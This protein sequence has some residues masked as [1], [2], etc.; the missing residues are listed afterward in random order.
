M[1]SIP[2]TPSISTQKILHEIIDGT[3]TSYKH[4]F[5][6]HCPFL[7]RT[8]PFRTLF[9][10]EVL[11]DILRT[12]PPQQTTNLIYVA[13]LP[14]G[15]LFDFLLLTKLLAHGYHSLTV[16][17]IEPH[18]KKSEI[19][20][21]LYDFKTWFAEL[22]PVLP[23]HPV[24]TIQN[25][26]SW[27]EYIKI[28]DGTPTFKAN[29]IITVD[30]DDK[31]SMPHFERESYVKEIG[32]LL[33]KTCTPLS[34]HASLYFQLSGEQAYRHGVHVINTH[35][36]TSDNFLL[37]GKELYGESTFTS[38]L[39]FAFYN[40]KR[41]IPYGNAN[42]ALQLKKKILTYPALEPLVHFLQQGT[43]L[44]QLQELQAVLL[45]LQE[46]KPS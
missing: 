23:Q 19:K 22:A 14:G 16:I 29:C 24:I 7:T 38:T 4:L 5:E 42:A 35:S 33:S 32:P 15:L 18:H 21:A 36:P 37:A 8:L 41:L 27:E 12:F 9:E 25:V 17:T 2:S 40:A 46:S 43:E 34:Y 45:A 26:A 39:T 11:H 1:T 28:C 30:P 31:G 44:P 13:H 10:K 3:R 20:E 6:C